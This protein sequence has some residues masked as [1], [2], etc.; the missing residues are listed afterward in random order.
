MKFYPGVPAMP[1]TSLDNHTGNWRTQKPVFDHAKCTAC[2]LC[3]QYCPEPCIIVADDGKFDVDL[4]YCKG[5]G[6]CAEVCPFDAIK[7]V[8]ELK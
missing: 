5:C 7:M 4:D 3:E 8:L 6:I 2:E 1:G